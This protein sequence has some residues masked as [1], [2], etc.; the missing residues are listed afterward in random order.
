MAPCSAVLVSQSG[1]DRF[2]SKPCR[3]QGPSLP[4]IIAR[5][6]TAEIETRNGLGCGR[7][8]DHRQNLS[9]IEPGRIGVFLSGTETWI[10]D[11]DIERDVN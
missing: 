10:D 3:Q 9:R 8:S 1:V 2:K 6:E 4:L 11:I 7:S 5:G